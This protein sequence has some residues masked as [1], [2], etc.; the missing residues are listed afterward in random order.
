MMR[1][2]F[3]GLTLFISVSCLAQSNYQRFQKLLDK[4]DTTQL[5][6]LF[7]EWERTGFDDP[8]FY[9]S[10]FFIYYQTSMRQDITLASEPQKTDAYQLSASNGQ[11]TAYLGPLTIFNTAQLDSGFT[12]IN[13][14]IAMFPDRLDMRLG[15]CYALRETGNYEA[16]TG[17]IINTLDHSLKNGNHWLWTE[18][19]QLKNG[20]GFML[21][22]VYDYMKQL[23]EAEDDKLLANMQ[24]I[25][26]KVIAHY[27]RNIEII[28][29]T[30]VAYMLSDNFNKAIEYF[31]LA[32]KI[33]PED[34]IVLNNIA[35][36]YR[37]MGDKVN[38]LKYYDLTAKY[39]DEEAKEQAIANINEL[40]RER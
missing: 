29:L 6:T 40:K 22:A 37:L 32:E 20:E 2:A 11:E 30:A 34:F 3:V 7:K 38:A 8:E 1:I 35:R 10:V 18:N 9:T 21:N 14:G 17:E 15:K 19:E 25:G 24:Q 16:F 39:G 27:P 28:S 13:K 4:K 33:D 36:T 12:Y 26:D 5:R 31:K 23:Y